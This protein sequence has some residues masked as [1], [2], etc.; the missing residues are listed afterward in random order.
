MPELSPDRR[1]IRL[2]APCTALAHAGQPA[3]AVVPLQDPPARAASAAHPWDNN[4]LVHLA[5]QHFARPPPGLSRPTHPLPAKPV[6]L[7]PAVLLRVHH[8]LELQLREGICWCLGKSFQAK[9]YWERTT[10][11]ALAKHVFFTRKVGKN[12]RID[13]LNDGEQELW[14]LNGVELGEELST[15]LNSAGFVGTIMNT[16]MV[17]ISNT[18]NGTSK[19]PSA[20]QSQES[21]YRSYTYNGNGIRPDH[22]GV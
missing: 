2:Q 3:L 8:G 13:V 6:C 21:S 18:D 22:D 15:A 5:S 1:A 17:E 10:N 11:P 16:N 7:L 4:H 19:M 12:M 20:S 9:Q 14:H